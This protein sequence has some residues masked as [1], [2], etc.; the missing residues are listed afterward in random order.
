[1]IMP[2][3]PA[4]P[5][6]RDPIQ[7]AHRQWGQH[8][9]GEVADGMAAIT[10]VTRTHQ[11]MMARIDEVLRPLGLTFARYELLTLLSFTRAGA[12]P[13]TK[14]SARLQVHPTSV[15][16]AVDRLEA[17]D[18]AQ[19]V[20]H[21]TDRRATLI[22]ITEAGLALAAT[23]TA[24]LNA[25]VF[26][27]PGLSDSQLRQLIRILAEFRQNAGDFSSENSATHK[28]KLKE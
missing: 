12:L 25:R 28:A 20:P 4:G 27:A 8:G 23:A 18:L 19:R 9:W 26:A 7:E 2:V 11:I 17:A 6:S 24:E 13:M 1:M 10:S 16:N 5:L 21:P 3:S 15:T 22:K 14:A